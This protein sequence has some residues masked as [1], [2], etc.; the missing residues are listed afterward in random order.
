M[1]KPEGS[2]TG[3]RRAKAE[4]L[5]TPGYKFRLS[6]RR[7]GGIIPRKSPMSGSALSRMLPSR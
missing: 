3:V 2:Y 7:S 1:G 5:G 6:Q 4:L